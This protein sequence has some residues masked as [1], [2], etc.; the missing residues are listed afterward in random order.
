MRA[1]GKGITLVAFKDHLAFLTGGFGVKE[2][3]FAVKR[4]SCS[5]W[6]KR[7]SMM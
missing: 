4:V 7:F 1:A 5:G 6:V 2:I 3:A